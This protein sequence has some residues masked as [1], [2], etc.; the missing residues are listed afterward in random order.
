MKWFNFN[1]KNYVKHVLCLGLSREVQYEDL[2]KAVA[3][4]KFQPTI[5]MHESYEEFTEVQ[6]YV[7]NLRDISFSNQN[8]HG[9]TLLSY[10]MLLT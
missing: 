4:L 1:D 3:V 6:P 2:R 7:N 10:D 9:D 8:V 5:I